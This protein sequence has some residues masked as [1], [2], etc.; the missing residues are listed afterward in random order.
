VIADIRVAWM[1][2]SW[3]AIELRDGSSNTLYG[4]IASK[5]TLHVKEFI[6]CQGEM[7]I[8]EG[9]LGGSTL[10]QFLEGLGKAVRIVQQAAVS[11]R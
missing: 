11:R 6:V 4:V 9:M 7:R 8:A 5:N 1:V 3:F 10:I 2:L